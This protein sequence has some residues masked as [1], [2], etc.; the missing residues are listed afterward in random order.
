VSRL[1]GGLLLAAAL[2]MV[3][4]CAWR[5]K[6]GT[7]LTNFM[8]DG[9]R[10]ELAAVST[11]LT[12]SPLTRT[13][14]ITFHADALEVALAAAGGM[15]DFL[16]THPEIEWVRASA[17]EQDLERLYALYFPRRYLF[18]SEE[19]EREIPRL[20]SDEALRARAR[21]LR[22][23]LA[24]PLA[25]L[26][27]RVAPADPLGALERLARRLADDQ[28]GL[29]SV[30]GRLVTPDRQYAVVLAGSRASP[31]ES[32][33][34]ARL[35]GDIDAAF[36]ELS[37]RLGGGLEM[38]RSAAGRFAVAAER[39]IKGDVYKI[40]AC[41]FLGVA[42]LFALFVGSLR[43]FLV[44][45]L[46]PLAGILVATTLGLAVFGRL[47]GLT[48]IFG[49]SLMGIAIDYSNHLLI[50]HGL[51]A[52]ESPRETARRIRGSL[53]LG[54]LTTVASFGGLAVT[55]FPAFREMSFFAGVGVLAALGVSLYVLPDLIGPASQ[56]PARSARTAARLQRATRRLERAPRALLLAPLL[57][58]PLAALAL[59]RLHWQDDMAQ[60]TRFRPALVQEEQRVRARVAGIE[61]SRFVVTLADDA[62]AA[63][64]R[65][66]E[67]RRR[68]V[69]LIESGELDGI[70]SLH[71]VLWSEDLQR[72]NAEALRAVPDL[73]PRLDAAF[74]A[75][76]F[77]PGAFRE[78]AET[79][80]QPPP[81]PL[82]LADLRQSPLA[83]LIRPYVLPVGE[84]LA[85]V[86]YLR[87]VNAGQAVQA[88]LDGLDEVHLLDQ[89]SFVNG[90][91]REFR[92]T[93][94][95]QMGVG[96]LL[97]LVLVMLRYRA[98]RPVVAA[99]L[100]AA[101]V[102]V[103]VLAALALLELPVNLLHVM[104]L[105]MVTGMGVD[106]GIFLVD[107]AARREGEG[108]T[109]LSLLMSCL[110]TAFVFGTLALSSQPSLRAIGV[111]TGLGILLSYALAPL[112][113][114]LTGL[115][116]GGR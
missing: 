78:F 63:V 58:L 104:A 90:I 26:L 32:G 25:P 74:Q 39:E 103:L 9:S 45:S 48:M 86:T 22:E 61:S 27:K 67:V 89:R 4:Y 21:S 115:R 34:Q 12:D 8:P 112:T 76:G 81:P 42:T 98:W 83:D 44:V 16:E 66:E 68:L 100:P 82:R 79:L 108:A 64:A 95:R 101:A 73:Y 40:G 10:S 41:S 13:M 62:D 59:P 14:A 72:R 109:L 23:R 51:S 50:H 33:A 56:L 105:L 84:R 87:G 113:L 36:A 96:A 88:A 52:G 107:S 28:T 92:Q 80:E 54:A 94:L 31:F 55:A 1:R 111:T 11:A 29:A 102:S 18:L 75:E 60:L 15:A 24:S 47:D 77:R 57:A 49:A 19:P 91:Y 116:R 71:A 70:R 35:Q 3:L 38:E 93:T 17:G 106:Y 97:V 46:P 7:D 110:T 30:H 85:V 65:S 43:G 99:F 53:L 5:L 114:S 20:T 6:L 2:A 37:A 69:P